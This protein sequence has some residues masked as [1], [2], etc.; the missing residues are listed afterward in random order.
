MDALTARMGSRPRLF[1]EQ[2]NPFDSRV[3]KLRR[4]SGRDVVGETVNNSEHTPMGRITWTIRP[5]KMRLDAKD[6]TRYI[7]RGEAVWVRKA[8]QIA[9]NRE[10]VQGQF[11]SFG[12]QGVYQIA[13]VT[14]VLNM[15][16]FKRA[17]MP[18]EE[19][20][21]APT[22]DSAAND[23]ALAG[24][25]ATDMTAV[26]HTT[27]SVRHVLVDRTHR[28]HVRNV[29]CP[30]LQCGDHL[31]LAFVAQKPAAIT[32]YQPYATDIEGPTRLPN[33]TED[34][35]R[36]DFVVQVMPLVSRSRVPPTT[37]TTVRIPHPDTSCTAI[38]GRVSY[39]GICL[40]AMHPD[41]SGA[42]SSVLPVHYDSIEACDRRP[43]VAS[44]R[45]AEDVEVQLSVA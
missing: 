21:G 13:V 35:R 6:Y 17:R 37:A 36:I 15:V 44:L 26:P 31:F 33:V 20:L 42:S 39:V 25:C 16:L 34:G 2:F 27:T 19:S 28:T 40:F 32:T 4:V 5:W 14:P 43:M 8:V 12:E 29:W 30:Q 38:P 11:T 10:A 3:A 1:S 9:G 24:V 41:V 45:E 22:P 23:W 18:L 7:Q